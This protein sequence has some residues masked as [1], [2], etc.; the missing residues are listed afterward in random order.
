MA[1]TNEMITK[2]GELLEELSMAQSIFDDLHTEL[3][4]FH[5]E[6]YAP[7]CE[8]KKAARLEVERVKTEIEAIRDGNTKIFDAIA[9]LAR[10][11]NV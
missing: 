10:R 11:K 3:K 8:R 4:K 2:L 6:I 5:N 7:M 9:M 1:D